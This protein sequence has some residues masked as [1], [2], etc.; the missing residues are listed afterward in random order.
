MYKIISG[1][2]STWTLGSGADL[3]ITS[4]ADFSK[5]VKVLMDDSEVDSANYT[6][7]SGSTKVMIKAA[8]LE[9]LA[10]GS[11]SFTIVST[12]GEAATALTI[13]AAA[14]ATATPAPAATATGDNPQTGDSLALYY[15]IV[16]MTLASIGI[17]A[18]LTLRLRKTGKH[19]N[20]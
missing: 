12:D 19:S 14:A 6:A 20:L 18:A 4:D 2:D 16:M 5:F 8:Y 11:H 10:P 7:V 17:G 13:T 9:T 3:T 1:A 15:W